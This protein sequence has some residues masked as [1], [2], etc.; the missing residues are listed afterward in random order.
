MKTI[1]DRIKET[2][3][4]KNI[5]IRQLC[6]NIGVYETGFYKMIEK[7]S[8][9]VQTLFKIAKTLDVHISHFFSDNPSP[10]INED[11]KVLNQFTITESINEAGNKIMTR[12]NKGFES[13]RL[14]G[15]LE[16]ISKEIVL[17]LS[18]IPG[19][20]PEKTERIIYM[21]KE[22]QSETSNK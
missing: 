10:R 20:I 1:F 4:E 9:K 12:E 6:I 13:F 8:I 5:S 15:W 16:F 18:G 2:A 17:Q 7:E 21:P 14:L 11:R 22:S 3:K 19:L